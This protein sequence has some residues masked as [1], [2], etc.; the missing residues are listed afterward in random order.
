MTKKDELLIMALHGFAL[1]S[2][3]LLGLVLSTALPTEKTFLF[4]NGFLQ[5]AWLLITTLGL[6]ILLNELHKEVKK[7]G[8]E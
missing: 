3:L 2:W 5:A 6:F 8:N 7:G 4:T 1:S